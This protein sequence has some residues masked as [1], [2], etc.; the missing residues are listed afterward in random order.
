MWEGNGL[1]REENVPLHEGN[2]PAKHFKVQFK[3]PAN[4]RAPSSV[5]MMPF[6]A[7]WALMWVQ[8]EAPKLPTTHLATLYY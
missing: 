3:L 5:I 7:F 2:G 8:S 4:G 1:L 6:W